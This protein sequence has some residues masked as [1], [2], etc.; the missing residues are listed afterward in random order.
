MAS[1]VSLQLARFDGLRRVEPIAEPVLGDALF[2]GI[3]ADAR[4]SGGV[5]ES[6]EAFNFVVLGLHDS[7]D[8][9]QR[10]LTS[11]PGL[12]PWL[13]DAVERWNAILE[14]FRHHG[15][16]NH[17]NPDEPGPLFDTFVPPPAPDEPIVV[18]TSV[19]YRLGPGFDPARADAFSEGVMAVRASMT[20]VSG[21][22]SQQSFSFSGN[23]EVDGVTVTTWASFDAMRAWAYGMGTHRILLDRH[24]GEGMADRTSFTRLRIVRSDGTWY[25]AEPEHWVS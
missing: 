20:A 14:P 18:M 11:S 13:G 4:A 6:R 1:H 3:G 25:G 15:T 10:F 7:A 23:R 9:A 12:V 19:G 22:H 21:L 2:H 8:A 17:L 16:A 24:R 5:P